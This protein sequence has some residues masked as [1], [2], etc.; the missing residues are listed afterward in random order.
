MFCF[1]PVSI[2]WQFYLCHI[3]LWT[4]ISICVSIYVFIF[5]FTPALQKAWA[6]HWGNPI[7]SLIRPFLCLFLV[8][9]GLI[10]TKRNP[11]WGHLCNSEKI[12][13]LT[14]CKVL[15]IKASTTCC[16]TNSLERSVCACIT[17]PYCYLQVNFLQ[18]HKHKTTA[19]KRQWHTLLWKVT[20]TYAITQTEDWAALFVL[21]TC[22][23]SAMWWFSGGQMCLNATSICNSAI[24][25][26]NK[27]QVTD[28]MQSF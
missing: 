2:Y 5:L 3:H 24:E 18:Q 12:F 21:I 19:G 16:M 17:S 6:R 1:F 4:N 26:P 15:W 7:P 8:F 22:F 23:N 10:K 11:C 27:Q 13:A 14:K 28:R 9:K 20:Q 25:K